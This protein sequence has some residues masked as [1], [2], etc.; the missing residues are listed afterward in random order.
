MLQILSAKHVTTTQGTPRIRLVISDGKNFC[1]GMLATA[2]NHLA[3]GDNPVVRSN[4]VVRVLGYALNSIQRK[5]IM[6]VLAL[7]VIR[8]ADYKIAAPVSIDIAMN[9]A[10]LDSLGRP[11]AEDGTVAPWPDASTDRGSSMGV[12]GSAPVHDAVSAPPPPVNAPAGNGVGRGGSNAS[13]TS[14]AKRGGAQN[15]GGGGNGNLAKEVLYPIESL[16][17]YQNK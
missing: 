13:R 14:A 5:R 9:A 10:G 1:Q 8:Y 6:I 11:L 12:S 16:S 17:P 4:S 3:E 7:D 2:I 15:G